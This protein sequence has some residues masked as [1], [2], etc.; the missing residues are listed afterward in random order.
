MLNI[1]DKN[2]LDTLVKDNGKEYKVIVDND[3]AWVEYK[4]NEDG[5]IYEFQEYGYELALVLFQ[6]L[7]IEADMC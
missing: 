5:S 1:R 7:G 6:Y 2:W 4:N 3:S